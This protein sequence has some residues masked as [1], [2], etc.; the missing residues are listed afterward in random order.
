MQSSIVQPETAVQRAVGDVFTYALLLW[1]AVSALFFLESDG[2]QLAA[3]C[4]LALW[5]AWLHCAP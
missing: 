5:L 1:P 3:T 4:S 2:W